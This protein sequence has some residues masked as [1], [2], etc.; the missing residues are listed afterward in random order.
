MQKNFFPVDL[1]S[2]FRLFCLFCNIEEQDVRNNYVYVLA[3]AHAHSISFV[4]R[5]EPIM[6]LKWPIMLL[7]NAPNSSLL[8]SKLCSE[9][10]NYAS[11]KCDRACK[12]REYLHIKI[13]YFYKL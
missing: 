4:I 9:I 11:G 8:C 3:M 10:E 7:S 1:C 13:A 12:T 2:S 6:L 5:V